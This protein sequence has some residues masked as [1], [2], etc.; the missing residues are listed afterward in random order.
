MRLSHSKLNTILTCPMTYR[1]KYKLGFSLKESKKPLRIG[2]AVHWG[3]E[4]E[5]DNLEEYYKEGTFLQTQNYTEEQLLAESMVYGYLKNKDEIFQEILIDSETGEVLEILDEYHELEITVLLKTLIKG[6]LDHE[7]NGIIDL[8]LLTKK[9]FIIIDYKTVSRTPD[10]DKYL[11]Q[12]YRYIFLIRSLF[13]DFPVYKIAIIAIQKTQI[14]Q[15]KMENQE[16][17]RRRIRMEYELNEK[18]YISYHIFESSLLDKELIEDYILNLSKSADFAEWID[19]NNA[20]YLNY[21]NLQTVYGKSDYYDI[22]MKNKG[23]YL[24][25]NIKDTIFDK[26]TNELT[27][28]REAIELDIESVYNNKVLNKYSQF[29]VQALAYYSMTSEID[30]ENLFNYLKKNFVT[31]DSLL[32]SYWMTMEEKSR[33]ELEIENDDDSVD[34]DV[35]EE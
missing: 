26:D 35:S 5:N 34:E 25:Y 28:K 6:N 4:Y 2:G 21:S 24:L 32:E 27:K 17:F 11:N 1:L 13:P 10:W 8:L 15:K 3:I 12:L 20:Y 30:K 19:T 31:D 14:R 18:K 9:G 23:A 33:R 29:E 16:Q 7:F 22:F